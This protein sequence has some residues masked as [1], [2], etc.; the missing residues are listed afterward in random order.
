MSFPRPEAPLR[1]SLVAV[2]RC[3]GRPPGRE[4]PF[5]VRAEPLV[6]REGPLAGL[7]EPLNLDDVLA[8]GC[9]ASLAGS[10]LSFLPTP[11]SVTLCWIFPTCPMVD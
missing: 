1:G 7:A 6:G 3:S 5:V 11:L 8:R 10:S 4:V 9:L 2:F